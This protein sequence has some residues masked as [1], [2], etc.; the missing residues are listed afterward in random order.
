MIRT[1]SGYVRNVNWIFVLIASILTLLAFWEI[2]SIVMLSIAAVLLTIFISMPV[3]V[4]MK[5]GLNRGLA[6]LLSMFSGIVVVIILSLVVFPALFDQFEVLF[7][8]VVPTG[9]EQLIERWNSGELF[10]QI[11][12]LEEAVSGVEINDETINQI[13]GPIT[14][15][16]GS[17][18]GSVIPLIGGVASALLST[19]I[20]I[21]ICLYLIAEPDR[22][23]R[24]MISLTPLWYR[25]R[26]REILEKLD[27]T[28]RAWIRVTGASMVITGIGSGIGLALIGIEQWAAL[29]VLAGVLSFIPNFGPIL[30][31]IPSIA[32]AIVQAPEYTLVVVVIIYGVS[33]F[34]SQVVGPILANEGMNLAPVLIL[35]GQI[36]FGIFFGFLGIMLAVPLTAMFVILVQEIY[37]RDV[38]GDNST[39]KSEE[40]EKDD[41]MELEPSPD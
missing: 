34:Q 25:D 32:V 35:L 2:R 18:S 14:S 37:V 6:I 12:F 24:G 28:A 4:F 27:D 36:V 38:L 21:F 3:R 20:V 9:V 5:T 39:L 29:G 13:V 11:P 16:L 23:I 40:I 1:D 17:I 8:D 15:A 19:L 41:H 31:V 10:E 7:T 26:T 30:A 33:F 22:Y